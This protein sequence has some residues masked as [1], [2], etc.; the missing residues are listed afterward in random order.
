MII[1]NEHNIDNQLFEIINNKLFTSEFISGIA[2]DTIL[3]NVKK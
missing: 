3:S 1:K 2:G